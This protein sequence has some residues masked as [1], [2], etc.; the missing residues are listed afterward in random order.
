MIEIYLLTKNVELPVQGNYYVVAKNGIFL[1]K[2]TRFIDT[3]VAIQGI[4]FLEEISPFG[5]LNLPQLPVELFAKALLFFKSVFKRYGSESVLLLHY[6]PDRRKYHLLCPKQKVYEDSIRGYD[7]HERIQGYY[8]VGSI[9]SHGS[10]GAFHSS[11]DKKDEEYFDGIHITVGNLDKKNPTISAS[12]VVNGN[13]FMVQP[14]YFIIGI[15]PADN[16][17]YS[18][19]LPDGKD[20]RNMAFPRKW[21]NKVSKREEKDERQSYRSWRDRLLSS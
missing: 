16:N 19:K 3:L 21:L 5:R 18:I 7:L 12:L 9:H 14:P 13:R 11:I 15:E 17:S 4:S 6:N 20:Y 1:R 2:K 8:L 10:V